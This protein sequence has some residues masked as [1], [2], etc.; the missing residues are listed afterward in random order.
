MQAF[1]DGDSIKLCYK[2][3]VIYMYIYNIYISYVFII[4]YLFI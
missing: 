3:I 4:V 2:Y 1:K